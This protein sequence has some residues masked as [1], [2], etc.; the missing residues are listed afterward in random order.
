[1]KRYSMLMEYTVIREVIVEADNEEHAADLAMQG[2][3][4]Y[5]GPD[6]DLVDWAINTHPQEV[7]E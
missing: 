4:V 1:M 5:E 7:E 6:L 2:E 3:L